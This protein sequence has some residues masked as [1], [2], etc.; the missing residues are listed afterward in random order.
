[1]A[2]RPRIPEVETLS[3]ETTHL[4]D[5]LN[6]ESDLACVLIATSYLDYAL[7]TL[8]KRHLIESSVVNRVL[9]PPRGSLSSFATRSDLA[10]CL[11]LISKGLRKNLET[12]SQIRNKFAHSHLSVDLQAAEIRQLVDSLIPATI[13]HTITIEEGGARHSGPAPMSLPD[14]PREKFNAIVIS[15]VNRLLL[16]GLAQKHRQRQLTGWE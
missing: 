7:A 16:T 11:G 15:M 1:M 4:C 2:S 9:E 13:H 8:L 14:P 12:I 3:E 5:I 10:Y 6:N